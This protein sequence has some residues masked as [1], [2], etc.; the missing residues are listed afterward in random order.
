MAAKG[1]V[2]LPTEADAA[3]VDAAE[4]DTTVATGA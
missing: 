3:E 4:V 1:D 2:D